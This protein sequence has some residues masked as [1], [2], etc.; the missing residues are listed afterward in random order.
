MDDRT[1]PARSADAHRRIRAEDD[2]IKLLAPHPRRAYPS[3]D[4]DSLFSWGLVAALL[5]VDPQIWSG[6]IGAGLG[7]I[8]TA[9]A[10]WFIS[11]RLERQRENHRLLGALEV[12]ATELEENRARIER[13][14]DQVGDRLTLHDWA[15]NKSALAALVVR[16][17]SLWSAV[18]RAYA[19]IHE[20]RG[21]GGSPPDSELLDDLVRQLTEEQV[22]VRRKL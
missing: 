10:T 13:H 21:G 4:V 7:A 20:T 2:A 5:G 22:S 8:F 12:V 6:V 17:E 3:P 18:A 15:T 14:G 11:V 1:Q 16:N 9:G 19:R